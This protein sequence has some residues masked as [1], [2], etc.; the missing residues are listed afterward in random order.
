M[1]GVRRLIV[2]ADDFG[3]SPGINAGVVAACRFGIVTSA[4]LMVRWPSA[5]E[6]A[7]LSRVVAPLTLGLHVDLGEWRF[8]R[9]WKPVY[10]V[11]PLDS[12]TAIEEELREQL[13]TFHRLLGR[14][15]THLDSHQHVHEE[16]PAASVFTRVANE[17]S[18]PL[19]NRSTRVRHCGDFYGQDGR[20]RSHADAISVARLLEILRS[21]PEGMTELVCHPAREADL[22]SVYLRERE[23]ELSVLC[24]RR[25][26]ETIES[27]GI[28]LCSFADVGA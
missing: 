10:E 12:E 11:V 25:V 26:L 5:E 2:N 1:P 22:E 4:S 19:R 15:P 9:A 23:L 18:V 28:V 8:D 24:D 17:L 13:R 3:R 14:D 27:E 16:E 21:L 6:A 7:R 20:G